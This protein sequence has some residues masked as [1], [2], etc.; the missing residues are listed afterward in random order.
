M[1][2]RQLTVDDCQAVANLE[3]Q[4]FYG[5][6]NAAGLCA[7][8]GKPAFYGAVL[9]APDMPTT[10]DAY[11]LAYIT[12]MQADVIAIGTEKTKQRCGLGQIILRHLID[13]TAQHG[14][15]EIT[16][17]V[18]ADNIPARRLYDSCGFYVSGIR[19]NYYRRGENPCDA[20]VMVHQIGSA[21]S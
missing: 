13:V 15:A 8:L 20:L 12:P 21:F 2:A 11:C 1:T 7:L 17:E 10:I 14:V 5:R 3:K 6:F 18:A 19:K 16:L 9:P 4:L